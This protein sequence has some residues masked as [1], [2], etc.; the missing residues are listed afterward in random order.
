MKNTYYAKCKERNDKWS[1]IVLGKLE[2][3]FGEL[4]A[5][6]AVYHHVCDSN[7]RNPRFTIPKRFLAKEGVYNLEGESIITKEQESSSQEK[8]HT[9]FLKTNE[10]LRENDNEQTTVSDL[11]K[12]TEEF[13]EGDA[14]TPW[15]F[16]KKL[17]QELGEDVLISK[18][19]GKSNVVTI[20]NAAKKL[21]YDYHSNAKTLD[22]EKDKLGFLETAAK[23]VESDIKEMNT[24]KEFYP[25][26]MDTASRK[27]N[28]K[29]VPESLQVFLRSLFSE[30]DSEVKIAAI[31]Q[32]IVQATRPRLM[33][34]P[35]QVGLGVMLH[36][37]CCSRYLIDNLN[38]MGFCCSYSE[39]QRFEANA[40]ADQ[41]TDIPGCA[42]G[43]TLQY[44]A[45]NVDHNSATLDGKDT[46]HLMGIM[47]VTTPATKRT[48]PIPRESV[49]SKSVVAANRIPIAYYNSTVD[50]FGK[51]VYED[52]EKI[53]ALDK[54]MHLDLLWKIVWPVR[55]TRPL[56]SGFMQALN[57]GDHPGKSSMFFLPMVDLN[58]S[59][60]SCILS[61]LQFVSKEAKRHASSTVLTF[62]QPLYW[63]S[64]EIKANMPGD[65]DI[66]SIV[67]RL[68]AF[69][70]EMSFLGTIGHIMEGTG[71]QHVL[72][73]AY[74]PNAVLHMMR[75]KAVSRAV[76]GHLLV[77]SALNAL[78]VSKL[79]NVSL[80]APNAPLQPDTEELDLVTNIEPAAVIQNTPQVESE[81]QSDSTQANSLRDDGFTMA[82]P[83]LSDAIAFAQIVESESDI[84]SSKGEP[85][86]VIQNTPEVESEAQNDSTQA[87]SLRDDGFTMADPD[88]S[89][90]IAFAHIIESE[91]DISSSKGERHME[92]DLMS[93]VATLY[94]D[95]MNNTTSQ[96]VTLDDETLLSIHEKITQEKTELSKYPT[97]VLWLQYMQ[98]VD[99]LRRFLKA[100]RTGEWNLHLASVQEM[101]P[102][103]AAS[104][105]SLYTKS[106]HLYLKDMQQLHET[107]PDVHSS[108]LRGFHVVR[109][110]DRLWGGLSTD[111]AIEQCLMRSLKTT[112]G[113]TRGHGMA[114]DHRTTW[115][116][117][118]PACAELNSAMQEFSGQ[119]YKSLSD[120]HEDMST[121]RLKQDEKDIRI[122]SCYLDARNPFLPCSNLKNVATGYVAD[123]QVNVH[124]AFEE[125]EK[126]VKGMNGKSIK[127]FTFKRSHQ[128]K[129]MAA[130]SKNAVKIGDE[131]VTVDHQLLFQRIAAAARNNDIPNSELF[132]YELTGYP[133]SLF[134]SPIFLRQS[135]KAEIAE[136]MWVMTEK[137]MP[138][139]PES[140]S[141][142]FVLDGGALL[143]LLPWQRG[144]TFAAILKTYQDYVAKTYGRPTIVFDG[145]SSSSTKDMQHL[146]RGG[147]NVSPDIEFE[148]ESPVLSKK[149]EFLQNTGN[150]QRFINHLTRVLERSC[151]VIQAKG[152]AD[153][154]I[155]DQALQSASSKTTIVVADDTDILV[156]LCSQ[157]LPNSYPIFLRPSHRLKTKTGCRSRQWHI[158][159]TQRVL[160]DIAPILPVIH[161]ITGCD[162][163]SRP[164]GLGKKSV[165]RKFRK[166]RELKKLAEVFIKQDKS[167]KMIWQVGER[168]LRILYGGSSSKSLDEMRCQTF[169]SKVVTASSFIQIQTLPPTCA[170][171]KFHS[172]RV[173]LQVQQ[174][175][176]NNTLQAKH[177]GWKMVNNLLLPVTTDLKPAPAVLLSSIRCGCRTG[178][179]SKARCSC[180][181]NGYYCNPACSECKGQTCANA[182][183]ID[184]E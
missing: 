51:K 124:N 59:D 56:W 86:A 31:G 90:A 10:F 28:L 92:D 78:L 40:A 164:Y 36:H 130:T 74:A 42:S 154:M 1:E 95:I 97:A 162:T 156:L 144:V 184:Q 35:L 45:D 150:K 66:Q 38:A 131:I 15:Y 169:S 109:R 160:G 142:A 177:W 125:G 84:S 14:Y 73:L 111:L 106:L 88:L 47:A 65:K 33:L 151:T 61:T 140:D 145:Y 80:P 12:K 153:T 30:K 62:D 41:N 148:P 43:V 54:T 180:K 119:T 50:E 44:V 158:Q 77:D 79:F 32:A 7:F 49:D 110:S 9:A 175:L 181:R 63:K 98:L 161:A 2:F 13:N 46:F 34:A 163:T 75:G 39:V 103:M 147:L 48:H 21:L 8:K 113:P 24:S 168:I 67:L 117:S 115:L 87:N 126:I 122:I 6:D 52:V 71:L 129:T 137:E 23:L 179:E 143:H 120:Q 171:A 149:N 3:T 152:D 70:T 138:A 27:E 91:S 183:P 99:I 107:H 22:T 96:N 4:H 172:S 58:P 105:H 100:E 118:M 174:W 101:L 20:R 173:Y 55:P 16:Q 64:Q 89:D 133:T 57:N 134:D 141:P 68:G 19:N 18:K 114:E 116:L 53:R 178:C 108:F 139:V 81:A 26:P 93:K 165:L 102:Y 157:A 76:R 17:E 94:D 121:S 104:G 146:K 132:K 155:V 159:F 167:E 123:S 72:E 82:D 127:E 37:Q 25:D 135:N 5:S 112:G 60:Y 85:A 170:A 83:D 69:H 29:Y 11:V 176:G 128:A 136:E 182:D 166:S